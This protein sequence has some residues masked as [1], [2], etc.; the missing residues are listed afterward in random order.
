MAASRPA[1][2][3]KA[4]PPVYLICPVHGITVGEGETCARCPRDP[5]AE[6]QWTC[7]THMVC[8]SS[9]CC[10]QCAAEFD[11]PFPAAEVS[12]DEGTLTGNPEPAPADPPPAVGEAPSP[13]P[14]D[15]R[16][17]A[18]EVQI[19]TGSSEPPEDEPPL[20]D[21][22]PAPPAPIIASRYICDSCGFQTTYFPEMTEHMAGTSHADFTEEEPATAPVVQAEL[23]TEREPVRN[24]KTRFTDEELTALNAQLAGFYKGV[25]DQQRVAETAKERA[26]VMEAEMKRIG[27]LLFDPFH[28]VPVRCEWRVS[29]ADNQK[30]LHRLDTDEVVEVRPLSAEDRIK[31]Q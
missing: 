26:K 12:H 25:L 9:D 27:L 11:T 1:R 16:F 17:N 24:L 19:L 30:Q 10:S 5:N 31:L 28:V 7:T 29:I 13:A 18:E 4:R 2:S 23:F 22:E 15:F 20:P 21:P 3:K 6:F 8:F 14:P